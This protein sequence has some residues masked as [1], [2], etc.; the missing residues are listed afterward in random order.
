MINFLRFGINK[1]KVLTHK[2]QHQ[3]DTK[4]QISIK[5]KLILIYTFIFKL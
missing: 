4:L 2:S 3:N 1:Y 5:I